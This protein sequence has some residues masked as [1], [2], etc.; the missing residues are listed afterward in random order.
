MAGK[1]PLKF[2]PFLFTDEFD[3]D[4][5]KVIK[6][7]AHDLTRL[8]DFMG[9]LVAHSADLVPVW[10]DHAL[11]KDKKK[12]F[13]DGDRDAHLKGDLVLIYRIDDHPKRADSEV[14][15]MLRIGKHAVVLGM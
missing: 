5:D 11:K 8:N 12:G 10:K 2:R 6:G 4:L 9:A 13:E 14:V 15:S 1:K 3:K 7:N